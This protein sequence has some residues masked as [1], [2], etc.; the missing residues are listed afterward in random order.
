MPKSVRIIDDFLPAEIFAAH[1]RDSANALY[2]KTRFRDLDYR[3]ICK[4]ESSDPAPL[5]ARHG[6]HIRLQFQYFRVY[7]K[8]TIQNTFIHWDP[9]FAT[10]NAILSL[11]ENDR[12]NGQ[13]AFWRH[14]ETGWVEVNLED[15]AGMALTDADGLAEDR[16]EL[17]ELI[18]LPP[19]RCVIFP[20]RLF[21]SRYPK[22]WQ[23]PW[24]RRIKVFVF[25]LEGD[26]QQHP[27]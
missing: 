19:N 9:G 26:T 4:D 1:K 6:M 15:R 8:D 2:E 3:G 20:T 21:H 11:A 17:V 12:H 13:F 7:E 23:E 24:P 14:R 16:W 5:F 22:V 27:A 25:D 18:E 10:Y